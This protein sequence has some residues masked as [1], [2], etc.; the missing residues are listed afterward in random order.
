MGP[1]TV[2]LEG[3]RLGYRPA[4]LDLT[5]SV[6][7]PGSGDVQAQ[8]V[9][10]VLTLPAIGRDTALLTRTVALVGGTYV[11]A[12]AA[13]AFENG[14]GFRLG[15]G[16]AAATLRAYLA[17]DEEFFSATP[18]AV[19]AQ[20]AD[21]RA[22]SAEATVRYWIPSEKRVRPFVELGAAATR[23]TAEGALPEAVGLHGGLSRW[24]GVAAFGG[25]VPLSG[26][27]SS[28]IRVSNR[29]FRTPF[30][31]RA[32]GDTLPATPALVV[33]AR[34]PASSP[35]ADGVREALRLTSVELG[36]SFTLRPSRRLPVGPTAGSDTTTSPVP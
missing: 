18:D 8:P 16:V 9:Q 12:A 2:R 33:T 15:V 3:P 35:F 31:A 19:P 20:A 10:A 7:T 21:I 24:E 30:G 11:G 4:F 6:G 36:L 28:H 5:L 25:V 27:F 29:L 22:L 13:L 26:R 1:D 32:T 23:W 34:S 14:W 17:G